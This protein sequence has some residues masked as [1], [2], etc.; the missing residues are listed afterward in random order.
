MSQKTSHIAVLTGDLVHSSDLGPSKIE[1]AFAAL[2]NCAQ[3][4]EK[5]HELRLRFTRHRGDGWQVAF[6][7]PW[8]AWRSALAFRAALKAEGSE[9]DTYIGI[10]DGHISAPLPDDLNLATSAPFENS[11]S[12][13]DLV[14]ATP[15]HRF[16]YH[17]NGVFNATTTLFDH[18]SG[19]WTQ[20]Q[21]QAILPKL[22]FLEQPTVTDIAARLGKSR[23]TVAKSLDAA[24]Y[25][26]IQYALAC[27]EDMENA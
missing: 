16:G 24:G 2:E 7:R 18:I 1:Q 5:W 27:L 17:G 6:E 23:Q 8:L 19:D 13:L 3:T 26:T 11:G 9:F 22:A 21:A 14:K 25:N 4:Q 20:A 15:G 12:T 10:A